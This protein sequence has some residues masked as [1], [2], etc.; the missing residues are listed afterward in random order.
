MQQRSIRSAIVTGSTGAVGTALCNRL[1]KAGIEVFAVVRPDSK[2]AGALPRHEK[3]H[4]VDCDA[5][6]FS[7][8]PD[9]MKAICADAFFSLAWANTIG[10]GRND[11]PSQ[12]DNIRH[13]IDAVIA[14]HALGCKVFIGTGSQAEYGRVEGVLRA[15]TPAFPENGY[16]M[17]K[18]CAGQ[19]SRV[20][21]EML[22]MDHVWVRILSVYG[23]HDGANSMISSTIRKL[24]NG[25]RPALTAGEQMWDYLYSE[26]SAEA[27]YRCALMG[28]S[29]KVYPLGSGRAV[30]LRQYIE[31]L[32]DAID[33]SLPLGFGEIP[34]SPLQVMHLQADIAELTADTGF[35]PTTGF[36]EGIRNTIDWVKGEIHAQG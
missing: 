9:R 3:L 28:H 10:A 16:G 19:M 33:P 20:E 29:G 17:A 35:E 13:T 25:E 5:T 8:L 24:L 34:Y 26:D 12:V 2:R 36:D 6:E 15:D 21:C 31:V 4:R 30:P 11:M 18:L 1:L 22:G 7:A 32:R 27:L 14:A 23:P